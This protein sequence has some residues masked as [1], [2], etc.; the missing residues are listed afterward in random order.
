MTDEEELPPDL[1]VREPRKPILP[2]LPDKEALDEPT[3]DEEL[4]LIGNQRSHG[5]DDW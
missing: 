4:E 1:G 3:E 5:R 2:L